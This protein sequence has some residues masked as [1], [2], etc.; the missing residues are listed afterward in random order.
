MR[1]YGKYKLLY[2]DIYS[3]LGVEIKMC[4]HISKVSFTA[5]VS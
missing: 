5:P 3:C 1:K 4:E 2:S